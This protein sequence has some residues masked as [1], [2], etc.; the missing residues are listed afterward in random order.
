MFILLLGQSA[1]PCTHNT[2]PKLEAE[3]AWERIILGPF[4]G[5]IF[6]AEKG[7]VKGLGQVLFAQMFLRFVPQS[8]Y[9]NSC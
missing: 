2:R 9:L 3:M 7:R 8:L 1:H 4:M 6:S 5:L